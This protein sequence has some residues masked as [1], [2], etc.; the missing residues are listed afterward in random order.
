MR[1]KLILGLTLVCALLLV[2]YQNGAAH[3]QVEVGDYE[4]EIGF[5]NEPAYLN[6][7]NSLDLFVTN[8]ITGELVTGL[9]DSLQAEI[10]F[11]SSK[12]T[13]QIEPQEE[14]GAYTAYLVPTEVG[15]YTWHI[16]GSIEGTPVDVSMTSSPD[17]FGSVES[18]DNY[19]FPGSQVGS[20]NSGSS[21]SMIVSLAGGVLGLLGLIVGL[22]AIMV[23][24][25]RTA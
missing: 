19:A 5:H 25:Q 1:G 12:K 10:I 21:L 16:F 6:Q 9:E 11:G 8:S 13:L 7:P 17:T 22:L 20:T 3:G 14:E 18:S 24:R 15:D 2:L 4:L 23:A